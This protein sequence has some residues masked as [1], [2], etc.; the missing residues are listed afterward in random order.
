MLVGPNAPLVVERGVRASYMAHAYDF[1]KPDLT[2]EYP[3]VDGQLSIRC[4]F[5]ALDK[6]YN[7]F[8]WVYIP[9]LNLNFVFSGTRKRQ[10]KLMKL[11]Q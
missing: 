8:A 7:R 6:C 4:Y 2:S 3:V 5:S 11:R 10:L 9:S 1:Y